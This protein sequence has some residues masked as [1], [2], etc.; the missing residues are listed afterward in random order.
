MLYSATSAE[1]EK[2]RHERYNTLKRLSCILHETEGEELKEKQKRPGTQL[3]SLLLLSRVC[4]D[5]TYVRYIH[6]FVD[7]YMS[8]VV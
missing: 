4:I 2:R 3:L 8:Y 1:R 5:V 7:L 6:I